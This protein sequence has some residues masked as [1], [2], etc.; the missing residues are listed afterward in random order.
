V[1]TSLK[2]SSGEDGSIGDPGF[3][4]LLL[5]IIQLFGALIGTLTGFALG[6]LVLERSGD[7][8]SVPNR[9]A[10]LMAMVAALLLFGYLAIPYAT[11]VPAR[12]AMRHIERASAGDFALGV[13]AVIV[14]LL[15]GLLLGVPL[16][17]LP[18]PLG[19]LA[20]P[21]A[22][23]GLALVMLWATLTKSEMLLP[24]LTWAVPGRRRGQPTRIVV[25]T[26]AIIDG[27][28]VDLS[29]TG[30]LMGT[31]IV[32]RFVLDELQ[33]IADSPETLRR[34]RGRRGLEML[35]SLQ[36]E[37]VSPVEITADGA[38][39]GD[40][41]GALVAYARAHNASILT[42][43]FN[44]NRVAELQGIRVL[45]I[46]ALANAVKTVLHPGEEM[47]VRIIQEGK[48]AGQGVGYLDDGTMIVVEQGSRFMEREVGVTVTRVLQT[49]AGRM[50]FAQPRPDQA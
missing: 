36:K 20:P 31:L 10:F 29:K 44:L 30:F 28:I 43:D 33:G 27:R 40:V 15:M 22:A 14:G 12:W 19:E 4:V 42:N 41:D 21:A 9:P 17:S 7:V 5:R 18:S 47:T 11:V 32:P 46:N 35:T 24:A 38:G 25:D 34:N 49:V 23:I 8:I 37:S 13:I 26:S 3:R 2:H 45:N 1:T 50:I 16:S 6:L 48:E 39:S